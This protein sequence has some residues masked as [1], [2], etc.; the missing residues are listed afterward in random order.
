M[1]HLVLMV[2]FPLI[3]AYAAISD[4]LTMT[5]S[6]IVTVSLII[7]FFLVAPFVGLGWH[8]F[9]MALLSGLVVFAVG[10]VCFAFG[11]VG[12]GDVKFATAVAL[13][14]GWDHLLE[15]LVLFSL[16]GGLLTVA[17]LVVSRFLEPLPIL[18]VGFLSRFAEHRKIPYGIALSVAA[19]QIYPTTGWLLVA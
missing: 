10:Y 6:N 7:A 9:G 1:L 13:W 11:W 16:Y 3:V 14:L 12:G 15:Y 4:F 5:I 18:Q 2:V 8:G 17:V 19:L